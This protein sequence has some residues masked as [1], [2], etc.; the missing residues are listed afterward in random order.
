[1]AASTVQKIQTTLSVKADGI[2][3]PKSQGALNAQIGKTG[4]S[5][6]TLAEIQQLIGFDADGIWGVNSQKAL[7]AVLNGTSPTATGNGG[8]GPFKM[9][10]SSFADP[11]DVEDFKKCKLQGKTD[12]Q[13]FAVGDNGIGAWGANTAQ[14]TKPMVA[15]HKI[16]AVAR[17]GSFDGAAHRRVRVTVGGVSVEATVEDKLGTPDRIDLNPAAAKKLGLNPPFLKAC[18]WEWVV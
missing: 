4:T 15:V 11:K 16:D 17:W 6:P 13:C 5:N 3:G 10:A 7:N 18:E 12:K 1:M 9:K 2:W 14:T 8:N